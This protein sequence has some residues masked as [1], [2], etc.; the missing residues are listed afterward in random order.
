VKIA[1]HEQLEVM[2]LQVERFTVADTL[3]LLQS[4][5]EGAR[6]TLLVGSDVVYT[7]QHRWPELEVLLFSTDLIIGLRE[8]DTVQ[9]MEKIMSSLERIHGQ[10][11]VYSVV[12]TPYAHLASSKIR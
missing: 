6:L 4:Q 12:T 1:Q 7:F 3:S 9:N 10:S 5:F 2:S 8:N 11:I